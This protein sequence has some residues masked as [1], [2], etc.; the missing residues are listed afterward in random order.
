MYIEAKILLEERY[1]LAIPLEGIIKEE[2]RSFIY[3]LMESQGDSY[4]LRRNP[5]ISG[6]EKCGMVAVAV[7]GSILHRTKFFLPMHCIQ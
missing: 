7:P 4:I 1:Q 6:E 5:V 3:T 2:K